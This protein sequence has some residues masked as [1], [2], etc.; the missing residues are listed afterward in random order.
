MKK[1]LLI[2]TLCWLLIGIIL[3]CSI[4]SNTQVTDTKNNSINSSENNSPSKVSSDEIYQD[5][6][7]ALLNPYIQKAL[8]NYYNQYLNTSPNYSFDLIKILDITRPNGYHT[9]PITIRFE[10]QPFVGPHDII[11]IDQVT[12]KV[13]PDQGDVKVDKFEHIKDFYNNLPSNLKGIIKSH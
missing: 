8:D 7:I 5:G 11:G 1:I 9:F 4:K 3:G 2:V 12:M 6:I 10:V 13:G